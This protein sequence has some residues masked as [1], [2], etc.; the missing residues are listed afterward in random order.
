MSELNV[1]PCALITGATSAIGVAITRQLA[2]RMNVIPHGR[3]DE[4]LRTLVSD[5]GARAV[6]SWLCDLGAAG[7]EVRA[8][9][10][11]AMG[12]GNS[13]MRI[14]HWVHA[15]AVVPRMATRRPDSDAM[16]Q[17]MRVSYLS[18][19]EILSVLVSAR[20]QGYPLRSVLHISSIAATHGVKGLAAYAGAKAALDAY[21]RCAAMEHAPRVRI[22]TLLPGAVDT[23]AI[24]ADL[25]DE[26][27]RAAIVRAYPLGI[28]TPE[29]VARVADWLLG[30]A[31]DGIT[32][33]HIVLD[34]GRT[35]NMTQ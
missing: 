6:G 20:E 34:G 4:A 35:V 31:S 8:S 5:L 13:A 24:A 11:D 14:T 1:Q 15:A 10:Q 22:N 2:Q 18:A 27:K 9:L 33:Q 32:G 17:A 25:A 28:S 21:L 19:V 30:E 12:K 26:T 16:L 23:P 3:R 7:D 29:Q